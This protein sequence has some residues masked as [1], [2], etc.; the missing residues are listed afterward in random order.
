MAAKKM[1][2]ASVA[3]ALTPLEA[4]ALLLRRHHAD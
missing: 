1:A 3:S 2:V 4:H